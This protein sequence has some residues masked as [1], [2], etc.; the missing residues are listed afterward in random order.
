MTLLRAI[1]GIAALAV[2]VVA[3]WPAVALFRPVVLPILVGR[4]AEE[5]HF[6]VLTAATC[7]IASFAL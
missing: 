2:A 6:Y 7:T 3:A 5:T 1:A 4:G